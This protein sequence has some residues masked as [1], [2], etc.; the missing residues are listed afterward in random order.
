MC[1]SP[2]TTFYKNENQQSPH[3]KAL[4]CRIIH[5][6]GQEL[7]LRS[8][9]RAEEMQSCDFCGYCPGENTHGVSFKFPLKEEHRRHWIVN[10]GKDAEWTPSGSS[11]LCSAHFTP[12]CFESGSAR[13]HSDA[14]PTL[15]NFTQ[16]KNQ[17]LKDTET[18]PPQQGSTESSESSR[19]SCSDCHK[20]LQATERNYQ[21]KLAAAQ[22]QIKE[23]KKN[24]AEESRKAAQ[25]QKRA[26]V[27]QSAIR[28]MKQRGSIPAS[29]K[30]STPKNNHLD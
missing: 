26:I 19:S 23:Y 17:M 22:L 21:L 11:S 15:F 7:W 30:T 27:L 18:L 29:R 14:I 25:W 3:Y 4:A 12:D 9:N 2:I 20:H 8:V 10:M 24:L 16:S 1:K 28:A 13:L 6:S 5:H